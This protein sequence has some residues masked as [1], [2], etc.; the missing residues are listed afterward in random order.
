MI[1]APAVVGGLLGLVLAVALLL[2]PPLGTD[3]SAQV[4]RADFFSRHGFTPVDLRWYGG[5]TQ[6]GYS[7]VSPAVMAI[8]G[9]RLTGAVA[10]VVSSIALGAILVRV[11]ALRPRA[12]A[13]LG[14]VAFAGNMVSGRVTFALGA[15]LGLLALLVLTLSWREAIRFPL[16]A[17]VAVLASATSPVAGAFLG[18]AG[19]AIAL[20]GRRMLAGSFLAGGAAVPLGITALLASDGGVMNISDADAGHAIVTGLVVAALVRERTVRVGALLS[21]VMVAGAY[22]VP[23]PVGLNATRL[24]I[25]FALPVT[26]ACAEIPSRL[27][28]RMP[29]PAA[30]LVPVL[31]AMTLWQPPVL[32][33]DLAD[34]GNPTSGRVYFAPL[35][36]E[37]ALR[38]PV[39]RVE[40]P[41]TR[42]YWEAAYVADAVPLARGWLRQ[43]DLDRNQLFFGGEISHEQYRSWLVDHGV[44][45]VALPDARLSWVG[46]TEARVIEAE[47]P[48]LRRVWHSEHWTLYEVEGLPSVV[49]GAT[50]VASTAEAVTFDVAAPGTVLVRVT[51]SRWLRLRGPAVA[52]PRSQGR[53]TV[54]AVPV[55]GRYTLSSG[56]G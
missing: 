18:V 22:L 26:A 42:N 37:L 43:V 11:D 14:A 34:A 50:L 21:S 38:Q 52:E 25:M 46:T 35:L 30:W 40:I 8:L 16:A 5:T 45:Y 3:L 39:G 33:G 55:S 19:A 51:M 2:A 27:V 44:A 54:V 6:Y 4:A 1:T 47:P 23:S 28:R 31:A 53:W 10:L 56:T 48:F 20:G 24:A 12:G 13:L 29:V 49:E 36:A 15:A 9:V 17:A 41:P 32:R 7:W